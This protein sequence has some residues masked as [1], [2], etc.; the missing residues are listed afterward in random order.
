MH[1]YRI[2]LSNILIVQTGLDHHVVGNM[3]ILASDYK[4]TSYLK[5]KFA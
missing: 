3:D 4:K 1:C 2:K 5:S